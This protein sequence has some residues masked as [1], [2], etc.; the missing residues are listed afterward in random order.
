MVI[1]HNAFQEFI[2]KYETLM[3]LDKHFLRLKM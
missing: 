1:V 3:L 2:D